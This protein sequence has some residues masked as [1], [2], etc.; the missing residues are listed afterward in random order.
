MIN[1]R[2][3]GAGIEKEFF[4]IISL[5]LLE[6]PCPISSTPGFGFAPSL[7]TE[8]SGSIPHQS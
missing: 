4:T 6:S 7:L 1:T 8:T 3:E 5:E 2:R